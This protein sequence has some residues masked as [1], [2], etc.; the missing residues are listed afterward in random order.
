MFAMRLISCS[1]CGKVHR[2]GE[3]LL[4]PTWTKKSTEQSS[5][6]SS[7]RW[8]Q[9]STQIRER[10]HYLCQAC[11][12]NLDGKG[13]RYTTDSLEVHHIVPISADYS[14]RLD[15]LNLITLCHEHHEQAEQ[16]KLS[17]VALHD[18]VMATYGVPSGSIP[19]V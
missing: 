12:H 9:K 8:T 5:F 2:Y 14:K 7:Y 3:C 16:H 13:V 10:D 6:R 11:L 4:P 18:V 17:A 19:P 15:D 1:R